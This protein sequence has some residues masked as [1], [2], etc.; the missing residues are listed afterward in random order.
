M[1][2]IMTGTVAIRNMITMRA[3]ITTIIKRTITGMTMI[4]TIMKPTAMIT[5][6]I[7]ITRAIIM[8]M[9]CLSAGGGRRSTNIQKNR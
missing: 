1:S 6:I 3:T 4:M 9:K 5:P 7:T 2:T 8:R